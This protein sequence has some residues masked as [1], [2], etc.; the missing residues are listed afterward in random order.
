MKNKSK[1]IIDEYGNKYW[2][3]NEK[4][5]K[6]DGPAVEHIYGYKAWYF[7]GKLHRTDGPAIEEGEYKVWF[8]NNRKVQREDVIDISSNITEREYIEFVIN[9]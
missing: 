3:L 2:Y 4:L 8:L 7:N 9:L 1:L 5:H 6:K